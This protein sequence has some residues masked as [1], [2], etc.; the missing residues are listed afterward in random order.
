MFEQWS[1]KDVN[2][3]PMQNGIEKAVCLTNQEL[4]Y[5]LEDEMEIAQA[6]V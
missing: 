2:F 4:M 3:P 5:T 6:T 1:Y